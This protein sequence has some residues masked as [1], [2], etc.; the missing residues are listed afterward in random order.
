LATREARL[1]GWWKDSDRVLSARYVKLWQD[2]YQGIFQ[3]I[4]KKWAWIL[5]IHDDA[6]GLF[7][8]L[9]RYAWLKAVNTY[10]EKT[11]KDGERRDF[12]KWVMFVVSQYLID[13]KRR[14]FSE[15]EKQ[16]KKALSLDA[17]VACSDDGDLTVGQQIADQCEGVNFLLAFSEDKEWLEDALIK[18]RDPK[19]KSAISIIVK[20]WG[21][22]KA[23]DTWRRL[24]RDLDLSRRCI[25]YLL[26]DDEDVNAIL[27]EY[28]R[29]PAVEG[30]IPELALI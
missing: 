30:D 3:S 9:W 6:E 22:E 28:L 2:T 17:P 21:R 26:R 24:Q 15:K 12:N 8:D 23:S 5:P 20:F 1:R 16:Q 25:E 29:L 4:A 19:A 27:S 18:I 13:R 7:V 14:S 10:D 11:N